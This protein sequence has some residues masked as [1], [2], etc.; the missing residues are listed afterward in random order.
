MTSLPLPVSAASTSSSS[1][2][3]CSSSS[4]SSST[5]S[6]SS[7]S[8]SNYYDPAEASEYLCRLGSHESYFH[9]GHPKLEAPHYAADNDIEMSDVDGGAALLDEDDEDDPDGQKTG[10][11]AEHGNSEHHQDLVQH[12]HQHQPQ[13]DAH[14]EERDEDASDD[15]SDS[16]SSAAGT[17]GSAMDLG[18]DGAGGAGGE[19]ANGPPHSVDIQWPAWDEVASL[20]A[21]WH[22]QPPPVPEPAVEAINP[23]DVLHQ[24][25]QLQA[26]VAAAAAVVAAATA[27]LVGG[28]GTEAAAEQ[29]GTG[30]DGSGAAGQQNQAA[31]TGGGGNGAEQQQQPANGANSSNNNDNGLL[32]IGG[33][34]ALGL[35][36]FN[37][38]GTL[39]PLD[40]DANGWDPEVAHPMELT[41]PVPQA[42]GPDNIGLTQFLRQWAWEARREENIRLQQ[43]Q[44]QARSES[45]VVGQGTG[46]AADRAD[47]R[48]VARRT[49]PARTPWLKKIT[50]LS[51]PAHPSEVRY[52]DL[53]GDRCDFQGIDWQEL[54]VTRRDARLRRMK[55][56]KNYTNM[57]G[58]DHRQVCSL[59][60]G[61]GCEQVQYQ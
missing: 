37:A 57:K 29:E 36:G 41:N 25:E 33:D 61:G 22:Q 44:Q 35:V 13:H 32:N 56:Y 45:D 1:A 26:E 24:L 46:N 17:V 38:F 10:I 54:G 18:E 9:D 49:T 14:D 8:A 27:S 34:G 2:S 16:A 11:T 7:S 5:S 50:E 52:V 6:A 23:V 60:C 30:G 42:L 47:S 12:Q 3:T 40:D 58:S 48:T 59:S 15:D 28:Q 31:V 39:V 53:A 55:T 21:S 51:S 43:Q 4:S 20:S 19:G